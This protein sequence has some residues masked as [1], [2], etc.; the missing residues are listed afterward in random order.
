MRVVSFNRSS[1]TRVPPRLLAQPG[2]VGTI[3]EVIKSPLGA[4]CEVLWPLEVMN[5]D[6]CDV[7]CF[8]SCLASCQEAKT[9]SPWA[10]SAQ[11]EKLIKLFLR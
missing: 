1:K 2:C 11:T 4:R 5:H 9:G 8:L 3:K 6:C 7:P 10:L